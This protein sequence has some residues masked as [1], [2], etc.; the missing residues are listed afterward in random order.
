MTVLIVEK[1][2]VKPGEEDDYK[3]V[4]QRVTTLVSSER[5]PKNQKQSRA[6]S[7]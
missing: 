1:Y 5:R 7:F 6:R 3:Q 4:W 2:V